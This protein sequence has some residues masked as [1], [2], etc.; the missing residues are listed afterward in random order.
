VLDH[1]GLQGWWSERLVEEALSVAA[2]NDNVYLETGLWWTDLYMKALVD[3]NVGAEKLL[4]GNAARV[5]RLPVPQT[6]LFRP[7]AGDA[8]ASDSI[9]P[10]CR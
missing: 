2:A 10:T 1:G 4:R 9:A 6:R 3:P 7:V 8:E 5:Y